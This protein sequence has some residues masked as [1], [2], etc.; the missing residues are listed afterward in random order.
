MK[1]PNPKNIDILYEDNHLLVV[2][3]PP[4]MPTQADD[5]GDLDLLSYLKEYIKI[6][7]EKPGDVYLGLI[8]RLDRPTSGVMVFA[9]TSKAAA[10]LQQQQKDGT[11]Q[12]Y[13]HA[14]LDGVP[15]E[16]GTFTD[17]LLK[18]RGNLSRVVPADTP[19]AKKA[20]LHYRLLDYSHGRSWVEIDLVTGRSH[21]IRVQFA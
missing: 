17:F 14:I 1:N 16:R 7:Y 9:R 6:T 3:K 15:E 4:N 10:R 19:G 5:S 2:I 18:E 12:K 21:Q 13:Y 20:I 8:Q 11:F